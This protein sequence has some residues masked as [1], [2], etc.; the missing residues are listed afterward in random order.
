DILFEDN[1]IHLQCTINGSDDSIV[2]T[3][4]SDHL[5]TMRDTF[6]LLAYGVN[7]S[8]K[9]EET[10][11]YKDLESIATLFGENGYLKHIKI[12]ANYEYIRQNFPTIQIL[13]NRV[14]EKANNGDKVILTGYD[15]N[16]FYFITPSNPEKAIP[17]EALSEGFK[18]TLVW[19]FDAIIRIVE[20]GGSLEN[21]S[22]IT[23]IILLDEV[24][25]HLHPSWQRT[26]LQGIE[27][28]F[29]NI[30]FIVTTHSPFVVQSA[31]MDSLIVLEM[32][33]GS[34]NVN[35]VDKN[36]TS[37]LSYNAIVREIFAIGFPFSREIELEMN[38]FHKMQEAIRDNQN[39][40]LEKFAELVMSIAGKGV[41][42]EGIMR[43]EIMSLEQRTGKSFDLWKK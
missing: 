22:G 32:E 30:Q 5:E 16:G 21:A 29:P 37:N 10:K 15:P 19:L 2:C 17:M 9:L 42:L 6:M 25:L 43:R 18:S 3:E 35:V 26:I 8:Y 13:I 31:N 4:G 41:E 1:P 23:G 34:G 33:K 36:I 38:E 24:D 28:L 14:L 7:R 12:S 40:D 39:V 20:K 27:T 11:P